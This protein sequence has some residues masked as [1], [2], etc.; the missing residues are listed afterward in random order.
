M[1]EL[2]N[3]ANEV[4]V[5]SAGRGHWTPTAVCK[6]RAFPVWA[7]REGKTVPWPHRTRPRAPSVCY[8]TPPRLRHATPLG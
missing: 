6:N 5:Y 1:Y 8:G 3:T 2:D 4:I 7:M